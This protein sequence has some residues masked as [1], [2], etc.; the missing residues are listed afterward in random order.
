[1]K[2]YITNG[3]GRWDE[4]RAVKEVL[5]DFASGRILFVAEPSRDLSVAVDSNRWRQDTEKTMMKQERVAERIA[6]QKMRE[7]EAL[8]ASEDAAPEDDEDI[9]FGD[10]EFDEFDAGEGD[11]LVYSSSGIDVEAGPKVDGSISEEAPQKREHKRLKH[12]GK[13]NKKLR[14]KNPYGEDN[15]TLAYVAYST[16]RPKTLG[17]GEAAVSCRPK[18]NEPINPNK[19]NDTKVAFGKLFFCSVSGFVC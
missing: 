13:K 6:V 4:F 9:V 12:W 18:R 2:G 3:T 10:G 17:G 11:Q 19:R 7:V 5:K 14:D 15:G 8:A 16:N 1:M